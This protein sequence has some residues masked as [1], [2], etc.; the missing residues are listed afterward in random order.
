MKR[1]RTR[2]IKLLIFFLIFFVVFIL[3]N[4]FAN[5]RTKFLPQKSNQPFSSIKKEGVTDVILTKDKTTHIY[6]KDKNWYV[7]KDNNEFKADEERINKII[8]TIINLKKDSVV[9]KNKNKHREIGI[10]KQKIEF[11]TNNKNY[12]IYV[13]A[14]AGL[15][16]FSGN[17]VRIDNEDDV[18]IAEGF[19]DTF[20]SDDYRNLSV[21]F[22]TNESGISNLEISFEDKRAE[23]IKKSDNWLIG[24]KNAKKDRVD[25]FINDLKTL[26]STDIFAKDKM[27]PDFISLTIK[28][29][30]NNKEKSIG[31]YKLDENNY[32]AKSSTSEYIYQIPAA[33]IASL[34][35]EEKD[36]VE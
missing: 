11:K 3:K 2:L 25:F 23:L 7:K 31:F 26:K 6:K 32:L 8:D 34:K 16:Q 14:L 5:W 18:F 9:S 21:H 17:F 24:N 20:T 15:S 12:L 10:D 27:I 30:E 19:E 1:N 22:V 28:I 4:E 36:F 13:G 35:K 33:Y 29:V